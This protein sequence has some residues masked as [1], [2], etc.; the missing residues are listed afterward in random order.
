MAPDPRLPVGCALHQIR[1]SHQSGD[2]LFG[3]AFPDPPRIVPLERGASTGRQG[4]RQS[5]K[6]PVFH[7]LPTVG[8]KLGH[9]LHPS[10]TAPA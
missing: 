7:V 8:R 6:D 5:G 4:R 10:R 1:R 2:L 9:Q 3:H